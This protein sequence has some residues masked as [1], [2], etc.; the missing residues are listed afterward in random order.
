MPLSSKGE[1]KVENEERSFTATGSATQTLK[2]FSNTPARFVL[3]ASH[4]FCAE[5]P[6]ELAKS[7]GVR[8]ESVLLI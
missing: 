3:H 7:T 5:S 6:L 4:S 8:S 2:C 1:T